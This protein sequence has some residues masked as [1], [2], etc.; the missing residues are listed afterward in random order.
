MA[1][2]FDVIGRHATNSLNG[3]VVP[4]ALLDCQTNEICVFDQTFPFAGRSRERDEQV[5]DELASGLTTCH[6]KEHH[7]RNDFVVTQRV[8]WAP[9]FF[10][11]GEQPRD[12][13]T[14]PINAAHPHNV[15][16]ICSELFSDSMTLRIDTHNFTRP[17]RKDGAI[18]CVDA[19]QV[20]HGKPG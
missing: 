8:L 14:V 15:R 12:Q 1:L 17:F 3:S 18:R 9:R 4:E 10:V 19:E 7:Q 2:E 16:D 6:Q 13:V 20:R 11:S 5:S